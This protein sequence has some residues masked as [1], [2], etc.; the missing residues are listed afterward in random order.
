M[1]SATWSCTG[2]SS[3]PIDM[4]FNAGNQVIIPAGL[5]LTISG[6]QVWESNVTLKQETSPGAGDGGK[7]IFGKKL[8]IGT[9]PGCGF[10]FVAE[11]GSNIDETGTGA[12]RLIIC[13]QTIIGPN[14]GALIDWPSGGGGFTGPFTVD[15]N[16]GT[17]PVELVYFNGKTK[18]STIVLNWAT[19][20]E[21][22][23][24]YF[25]VERSADAIEFNSLRRIFSKGGFDKITNYQFIDESPLE[26][27][28]Y[29][30][31]KSIDYDGSFEYHPII[32]V[33][34]EGLFSRALLVYPN[35]VHNGEFTIQPNFEFNSALITLKDIHG[36]KIMTDVQSYPSKTISIPYHLKPG[37][38][39][40]EFTTA[41]G[42]EIEKLII[43]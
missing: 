39:I 38:Y 15:E 29:Y 8:D 4:A 14:A 35:P 6:N 9:N 13:G 19:S 12:D 37:V 1:G 41:Q 5:T 11:T 23:F 43:Q 27:V 18:S 40:L 33:N 2:T 26:G 7:I 10:T 30:R 24:D 42:V 16:G 20:S 25:E 36:R 31:L 34:Y 17:L 21:E 28:N 3:N 22:N 32:S